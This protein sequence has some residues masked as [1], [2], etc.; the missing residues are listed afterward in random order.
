MPS[1]IVSVGDVKA[2][3]CHS[4][5]NTQEKAAF[6]PR[7]G[8][9]LFAWS[10]Q[11][12]SSYLI[13]KCERVPPL[14][15]PSPATNGVSLYFSP[16]GGCPSWILPNDAYP[17]YPGDGGFVIEFGGVCY[18]DTYPMYLTCIVHV[19]CMYLDVSRQDTSRYIE[20]QQDTFVSVTLAII[21]NVSYL[22]ISILLYDTF[23]IQ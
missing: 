1:I 16:L 14:G 13:S 5:G 19:S 17:G 22:R 3:D 23:R 11:L 18:Q 21:G 4:G 6:R 2:F 10:G 20:I 7:P 15:T 8:A 12:Q 9:D